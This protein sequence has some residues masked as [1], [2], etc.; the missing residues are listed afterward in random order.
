MKGL[1]RY[2]RTLFVGAIG[3]V[4]F[5]FLHIPLAWMLGAIT[6]VM[7][8]QNVK[9]GVRTIHT[10]VTWRNGA[11]LVIGCMIGVS[12][13][14]DAASELWGQ[15]PTML[16]S[17]I[18]LVSFCLLVGWWGAKWTGMSIQSGM[19]GNVP[20]GLSQMVMLSEEI[21]D[22]DMTAVAMMQTIRIMAVIFIVPMLVVHGIA[23]SI[24]GSSDA[25]GVETQAA[26]PFVAMP[27]QAWGTLLGCLLICFVGARI[28]AML[29]IPTPYLLGPVMVTALWGGLGLSTPVIPELL[30]ILAQLFI[31]CYVGSGM[32]FDR[33]TSWQRLIPFSIV[34]AVLAVL[35]SF[36]IGY[37]LTLFHSMSIATAFLS[38]APGGMAE[39]GLTASLVR[40]DLSIVSSY[41]LFRILFIL[42][43]VP[44]FLRWLLVKRRF[45]GKKQK[46]RVEESTRRL[47]S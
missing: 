40:A 7:I 43:I 41:Q 21:Q 20:G 16:V 42:F 10:H 12:F 31:G 5:Y 4:V 34:T 1:L 27:F 44:P 13:T 33:G 18:L 26:A 37:G 46:G 47:T 14:A 38:V 6:A 45:S 39:M 8:V 22:A 19:I 30:L 28:A 25:S 9:P 24:P 11:L 36:I 35:F 23:Q 2:G 17:N 29:R 3:A 32:K 15:L